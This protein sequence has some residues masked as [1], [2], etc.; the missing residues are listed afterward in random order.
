[1]FSTGVWGY[2]GINARVR[3]K[4]S[5]RLSAEQWAEFIGAADFS[6]LI[7]LLRRSPYGPY[8]AQGAEDALTPRRAVYLIEGQMAE[9]YRTVIRVAP[10]QT[11]PLLTL[12]YR[13]FEVANLKAVLRGIVSQAAWLQVKFVLFPFGSATVLPAEPMLTTKSVEAAVELLRGTP[14]YDPLSHALKRYQTEQGLFPLEVALDL[15]YWR[16]IWEAIQQLAKPDRMQALRIAGAWLDVT[17][18]MWAIRYRVYYGLSPEELIN[19][20]LPWGYEV[21]DADI[22][23]IAGG[24]EIAPIVQRIYP[25]IA[26]VGNLLAQPRQGLPVLEVQLQ[27]Q[28][29]A[30]CYKAMTGN[31]FHIGVPLAYLVLKKM[32]IQDLTVLLEAKASHMPPEVFRPYLLMGNAV[33]QG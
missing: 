12:L 1:V 32:E 26:D 17:N 31:P 29:L 15:S 30:H 20:T 33:V 7:D 5:T 6:A 25:S 14:Y 8:L 4:Y 23:A 11:C 27:R 9:A 3:A 19:Y 16:E 18:L 28:V 2:A 22:R 24:A 13:N 10:R 21:R